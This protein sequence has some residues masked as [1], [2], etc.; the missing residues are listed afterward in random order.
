[1]VE[2]SG[3][4]EWIDGNIGSYKTMKYPCCVLK[5]DNASGTCITISVA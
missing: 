4:M 3:K 1:M 2:T 5:G